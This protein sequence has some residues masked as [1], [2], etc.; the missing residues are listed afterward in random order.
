MYPFD[1]CL[2]LGN[3]CSKHVLLKSPV[4]ET[5][6]QHPNNL[7][8]ECPRLG[9]E[10]VNWNWTF[11]LTCFLFWEAS[12]WGSDKLSHRFVLHEV[13]ISLVSAYIYTCICR[14]TVCICIT[15]YTYS[16]VY[17]VYVYI[18]TYICLYIYIYIFI[19]IDM[20]LQIYT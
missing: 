9:W 19:C 13:N 1:L 18:H 8:F 5:I 6:L 20:Y 14:C 7:R 17:I 10:R 11:V 4:R 3:I 16:N 12:K 15:L 2:P